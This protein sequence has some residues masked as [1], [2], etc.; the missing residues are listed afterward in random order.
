[1]TF[2]NPISYAVVVL[3]DHEP[4]KYIERCLSEP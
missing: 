4:T 1:M 3:I 2:N